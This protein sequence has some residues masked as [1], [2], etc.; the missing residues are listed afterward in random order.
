MTS[1]TAAFRVGSDTVGSNFFYVNNIAVTDDVLTATT[2]VAHNLATGWRVTLRLTTE[3]GSLDPLYSGTY[4]ITEVTD[5]T[6][7]FDW[8]AD[9][10]D[11]D[12]GPGTTDGFP[13]YGL[14]VS[15]SAAY[16]QYGARD[17]Q[18]DSI[19]A[20]ATLYVEPWD[21][22]TVRVIWGSSSELDD[23]ASKDVANG[24][25]PL[26]VITR[27]SMGYPVT[28]L[29][30]EIVLRRPYFDVVSTD[31]NAPPVS[32]I[33]TQPGNKDNDWNRPVVEIQSLYDRN[34]PSGRWFY[35]SLFFFLG[36]YDT[37]ESGGSYAVIDQ[38]WVR[39]HSMDAMTP[40]NHRH[41]EKLYDLLPQYYQS[42]DQQF[43]AGTGRDGV[44]QRLL[45]V[46]GFETDY[47]K[48]LA[49][50]LENIYDVD[51]VHDD[52][53]HS[54][55]LFNFGV[56]VEE[57]LGDGR[58][59]SLLAAISDLYELRG[60]SA[61]LVRAV[62]AATKYRCKVLEGTNLLN[63]ADDA[64]FAFGTGAWGNLYPR[65]TTFITSQS[66]LD[67][68]LKPLQEAAFDSVLKYGAVPYRA[69]RLNEH[70]RALYLR[71]APGTGFDSDE[72]FFDDPGSF[73]GSSGDLIESPIPGPPGSLILTCGL[74]VGTVPGRHHEDV[75]QEFYPRSHGVKCEPGRIYTFSFYMAPRQNLSNPGYTSAGIM[76]FNE[77]VNGVFNIDLDFIG[78]EENIPVL[79]PV[80]GIG[81]PGFSS[82]WAEVDTEDG[83]GMVRRAV[84]AKAPLAS[85]GRNHVF[86]VPY[87]VT[88]GVYPRY[89]T[90]CMF[91][92]SLNS[93][94]DVVV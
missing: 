37:A 82:Y 49:D 56:P 78:K 80:N 67:G 19:A 21:Y 17:T 34:L 46:V 11:F 55:G 51:R 62:T 14:A 8:V 4:T 59:R 45:R 60:S 40:V 77:P 88:M 76:W 35:Y 36:R 28:P 29:D 54:L 1:W 33:E 25:T 71:S 89:I 41:A 69:A 20:S 61:G 66:W 47:T 85:Q 12:L 72:I 81:D 50:T 86:A 90:A 26:L 94:Q 68:D 9:D 30:G 10:T 24:L 84:T 5:D 16:L 70:G 38:Q 32:V 44:L 53:L 15:P 13:E 52:L 73:D 39:A 92:K 27:S 43:V 75:E 91:N 63:L 87:I 64:E 58:Y 23:R 79:D 6:F 42:L 57:A 48:S 2:T 3:D 18:I 7:S 22:N 74:G 65:Y 31:E 83:T 93:A